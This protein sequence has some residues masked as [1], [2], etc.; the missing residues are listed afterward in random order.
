MI[1]PN[2]RAFG[3]DHP[4]VTVRDFPRLLEHYRQLGFSPSPVGYHPWGTATSLMMFENNFIELI[5]VDDA[6]KFGANAVDG[7]CFGRFLGAF[8]DRSEGLS[9]VAL[10]SK[11]LSDD[12]AGAQRRGLVSQGEIHFRRDMV[13]PDGSPGV[14]VVQLGMLLDETLGDVSNFL[15][16]QHRPE[17]IWIKQWQAHP[18]GVTGIRAVSYLAADPAVLTRR[19]SGLYGEGAVEVIDGGIHVDTGAGQLRALNQ[20]QAQ[21]RY[22]AV[23]LPLSYTDA[24][25]G[26][27]VT[28]AVPSLDKVKNLFDANGVP[29][30]FSLDGI[31]AAPAF[32]GNVIL[33]FVETV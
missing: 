18:N 11:A 16:Q 8:L 32:C 29:Y 20:E 4:L 21:R 15:C 2:N 6:G 1:P 26:F 7:F 31:G 33:E 24:P 12:L 9:L 3:I 13:N 28:L 5:G 22:G 10:H 30:G 23:G 14:A 17:L 19:W 27:A 25:H